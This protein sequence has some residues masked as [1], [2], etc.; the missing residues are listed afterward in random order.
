MVSTKELSCPTKIRFTSQSDRDVGAVFVDRMVTSEKEIVF[1][2]GKARVAV[3]NEEAL[4]IGTRKV[5]R[6]RLNP[7][8]PFCWDSP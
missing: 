5:P 6:C 3:L 2:L 4:L 1:Y 8:N 7:E